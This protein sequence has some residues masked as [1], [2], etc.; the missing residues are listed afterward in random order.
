M[1]RFV[2]LLALAPALLGAD[3]GCHADKSLGGN[4]PG[5]GGR[6]ACGKENCDPGSV[7]CDATCGVCAATQAQCPGN[8]TCPDPTCGTTT[9]GDGTSCCRDSCCLPVG[10]TCAAESCQGGTG[11]MLSCG[12]D[13]CDGS[14]EVCCMADGCTTCI[15]QGEV[16][17]GQQCN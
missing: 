8:T 13:T 4:D 2:W 5:P 6:I 9:C 7:C 1:K 12:E 10:Q 16:C 15:P 3:D 17:N 11:G 14:T